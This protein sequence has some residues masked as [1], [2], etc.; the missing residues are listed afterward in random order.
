MNVTKERSG[1]VT[2]AIRESQ[3]LEH[4]A[5]NVLLFVV[6]W[7]SD[8]FSGRRIVEKTVFK[9]TKCR[10]GPL[11]EIEVQYEPSLFRVAD[12]H[13]EPVREPR[14]SPESVGEPE[15]PD[16]FGCPACGKD[17]CEGDCRRETARC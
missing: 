7:Q 10:G 6:D 14:P 4:K 9:A 8:G 3:V 1:S 13:P 16:L 5:S 17:S 11:F 12:L 15:E 2:Y